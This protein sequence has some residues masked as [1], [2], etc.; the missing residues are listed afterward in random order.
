MFLPTKSLKNIFFGRS[1]AEY[2]NIVF[3]SLVVVPVHKMVSMVPQSFVD[4]IEGS[5]LL[6]DW[7]MSFQPHLC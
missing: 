2:T 4:C 6:T 7:H 1:F 3:F 5:V